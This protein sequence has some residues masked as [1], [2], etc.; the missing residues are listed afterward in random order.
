MHKRR[1][2]S[3]K[4]SFR[5]NVEV[6]VSPS[7]GNSPFVLIKRKILIES[8]GFLCTNNLHD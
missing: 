7:P 4:N 3:E 8:D 6:N 2:L 1:N 5:I